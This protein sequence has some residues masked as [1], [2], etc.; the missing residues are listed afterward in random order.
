MWAVLDAS[1]TLRLQRVQ[2]GFRLVET[3]RLAL[4]LL[5]LM[6]ILP[7]V[8]TQDALLSFSSCGSLVAAMYDVRQGS[9][10]LAVCSASSG[11][12]LACHYLHDDWPSCNGSRQALQGVWSACGRR[13]LYRHRL[14]GSF[15]AVGTFVEL[16]G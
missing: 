8:A 12:L 7:N 9:T 14:D 4:P 15:I 11:R 13:L 6:R 10:M 16:T 1:G 2:L 3:A 5:G